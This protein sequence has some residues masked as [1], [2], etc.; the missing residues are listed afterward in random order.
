MV[1]P[2]RGEDDALLTILGVDCRM[3]RGMVAIRMER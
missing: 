2:F 3:G 1:S